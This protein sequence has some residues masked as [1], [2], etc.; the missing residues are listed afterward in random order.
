MNPMLQMQMGM[1]MGG[2]GGMGITAPLG[3]MAG[4]GGGVMGN[5]GNGG[6][7]QFSQTQQAVLRHASPAP[8]QGQQ[9]FSHGQPYAY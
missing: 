7:T 5:M 4:Y 2:M 9:S 3:G 8:S 6:G 1:G